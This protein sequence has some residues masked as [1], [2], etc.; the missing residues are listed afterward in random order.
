MLAE[1]RILEVQE[2]GFCVL[3]GHFVKSLIE[4]CHEDF[5]PILTD[6]LR[7][8]QGQPNR[9]SQRH[10]LPM[11]FD[12]KGFTPEFF[13]DP[14]V[15]RIV[16]GIMEERIVVDQYSCDVAVQGSTYQGVHVDYQRPLF[17]ETPDLSLPTYML[18]ASFGLMNITPAHGPIAI[19]PGT[20]RLPRSEAIRRVES[21]EIEMQPVPLGLGDLLIRHPWALHQGTPN[22]TDTPRALVSIRYVRRWYIDDSRE[23]TTIPRA[24]W[25][26]LTAE[27]Q[28]LL[29]FPLGE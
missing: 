29:R 4:A 9:G 8:H 13:F 14:E 10:F 27:Q 21:K 23:V 18:V 24:V 22:V 25:Q 16:R 6:Y 12:A 20:H 11:P 19:A 28:S 17:P 1:E 3:K 26:S 15:L 2:K 5:W 7:R